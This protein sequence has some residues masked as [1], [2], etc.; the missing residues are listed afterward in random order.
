LE[1][2]WKQQAAAYAPA[3]RRRFDVQTGA[4]QLAALFDRFV[5]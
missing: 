1:S 4:R 2:P 3:A 5:T